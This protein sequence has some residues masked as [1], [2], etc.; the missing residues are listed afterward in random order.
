[1]WIRSQDNMTLTEMK[2]L[3]IDGANQIWS[4]ALL[5][6]KYSTEEKAIDVLNLIEKCLTE[7]KSNYVFYMPQDSEIDEF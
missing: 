1:M 2:E 4:G 5:I 3:D 6:G 7:Y